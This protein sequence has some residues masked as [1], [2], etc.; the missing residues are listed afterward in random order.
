MQFVGLNMKGVIV[1]KPMKVLSQNLEQWYKEEVE[2]FRRKVS[3]RQREYA[4]RPDVIAKKRERQ[5]KYAKRP[6]IIA[7]RR[8]RQREYAK[9]PDIIAK[10]REYQ[11]EYRK[12][13]RN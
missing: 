3:I 4:K 1:S 2:K 13:L 10:K 7:K 6:D 9:R 5:R 11:R 12:R 8:E